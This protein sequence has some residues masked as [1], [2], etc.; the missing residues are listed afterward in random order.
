[1]PHIKVKPFNKDILV[2]NGFIKLV[3][4]NNKG[5]NIA[6][7]EKENRKIFL[8]IINK[9]NECLIKPNSVTRGSDSEFLK[10]VLNDFAKELNLEILHKNTIVKDKKPKIKNEALKTIED[11]YDFKTDFNK[12]ELEVGFGSGRHILYKA[13]KNSDTLYIGVEIH[14]PSIE[15]VLKQIN[16]KNLKNLIVIK[17]D[18]RLLL[19]MLKSNFLDKIYVHFPVPWDKKPHR[20]VIN[21]KFINEALRVLKKDCALELRTDSKNYYDYSLELFGS[22]KESKFSVYKNIDIEVVSKYEDRWKRMKK[23]IYTLNLYSLNNSKEVNL[24]FNFDTS[25]K[26]YKENFVTKP[27]VKDDYFVH[28]SKVYKIK[29]QKGFVLEVSFGNFNVVERKMVILKEGSLEYLPSMPS[30]TKS[31]YKAHNLLKE[32]LNGNYN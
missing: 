14:T 2:P 5:E 25:L 3:A 16:L 23:D 11:F 27:I 28:I 17:Y 21:E 15:Q 12:V 26:E 30:L 4:S 7:I 1:M 18:A 32:V 29:K 20:R 6:L 31:N 10:R 8:N 22:L 19:E 24:K 13:S 9:N